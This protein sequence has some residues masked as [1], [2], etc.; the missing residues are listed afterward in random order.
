MN[1]EMQT[2]GDFVILS[3]A[4]FRRAHRLISPT[5][6]KRLWGYL[7]ES[8]QPR[9]STL[10]A[11]AVFVGYPDFARF[12][13]GLASASEVQSSV[14]LATSIN[15]SQFTRGKEVTLRWLPDRRCRVRY[16][17]DYRFEVV[18]AENTK[19]AVGDTFRC[20]L[21]VEGEPLYLDALVHQGQPPVTYVAGRKDG[22]RIEL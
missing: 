3:E 17:G 4:V 18:E 16:L 15:T 21:M 12:T 9:R 5:T 20:M 22:V 11:L 19:L 2:S 7:D 8:V 10:D 6:L 13:E 1:A 14:S